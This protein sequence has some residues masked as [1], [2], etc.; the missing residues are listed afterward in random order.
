VFIL[1][2]LCTDA[3]SVYF[4]AVITLLNV[5]WT[6]VTCEHANGNMETCV[7]NDASWC[8]TAEFEFKISYLSYSRCR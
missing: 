2:L 5:K 6:H 3:S 8:S 1:Q 4:A 7:D